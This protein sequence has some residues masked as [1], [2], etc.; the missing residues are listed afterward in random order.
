MAIKSKHEKVKILKLINKSIVSPVT[1]MNI[2]KNIGNLLAKYIISKL[3]RIT[4]DVIILINKL[5]V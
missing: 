4:K 1:T 5:S 2:M 3:P